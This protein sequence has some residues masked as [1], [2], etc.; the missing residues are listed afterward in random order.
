MSLSIDSVVHI[1]IRTSDLERSLG[2][3]RDTLGFPETMR[4]YFTDGSVLCVYVRASEKTYLEIFPHG[5]GQAISP[6]GVGYDHICFAVPD[7]DVAEQTLSSLGIPLSKSFDTP[8]GRV[9]FIS[10]P[11]GNAI[12]F[13]GRTAAD[14]EVAAADKVRDGGTATEVQTPFEAPAK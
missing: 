2:F 6:N 12:E 8:E 4:H 7:A 5:E 11:D 14:V 9:L 1:A 10:D 13:K 3:Y